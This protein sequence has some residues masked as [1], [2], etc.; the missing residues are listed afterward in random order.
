MEKI[1]FIVDKHKNS[2]LDVN[3]KASELPTTT[4]D[5]IQYLLYTYNQRE[6]ESSWRSFLPSAIVTDEDF[7]VQTTSFVL[8][9]ILNRRIFATIGG[10]GITVIKR[11]LNQTFGLD[12]YEKISEPENDIV[13]SIESRGVAGNMTSQIVTYRSEQKL[14]DSLSFG[15]I[16]HR[17]NFQLRDTLL[18]DVFDFIKFDGAEKVCVQVGTSFH[19]KWKL[20]FKEMHQLI[21]QIDKILDTTAHTPISSFVRIGD[22]NLTENN[23]RFALYNRVRDDMVRAFEPQNNRYGARLDYDFVHPSKLQAFYEC[24]KYAL[25]ERGAQQPFFETFDRHALYHAG[26]T[27]LYNNTDRTNPIDFN[28]KISGIRV[29]GYVNRL[30]KTN[31]MFAHHVTCEIEFNKK[32]TFHIDSHWYT[33]KGNFIEDINTLCSKS[34]KNNYL[35]SSVNLQVW[36]D[37]IKD[38]GQY[39]MLYHGLPNYLVLDKML[40]QN[41]ELCDILYEDDSSVYL[42]HVKQGFDAKIRDLT[43]QVIISA[44]RLWNDLKSGAFTFIDEV[45][46]RYNNSIAADQKI[47]LHKFRMV[48]K[49]DIIY[50]M[51]FNSHLRGKRIRDDISIARSNIAKFSL[52]HSFRD[53]PSNLYP[54]KVVEI[55]NE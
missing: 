48:F 7:N 55:D 12:L 15:R 36:G 35:N 50:V 24:D 27:F 13:N 11:Y 51:A 19:I 52:I 1:Y 30:K 54:L 22:R 21:Q 44:N 38:E 10:N 3:K 47:D 53:M 43:N 41:I 17:L 34:I 16:P 37:S 45:C 29:C 40:G 42:I 20:S 6:K 32:P 26:L 14:I 49:K 18:A 28:S 25:Y 4:I 23:L 33:I 8:F 2:I 9:A 5:S 46:E 39:N 31:A